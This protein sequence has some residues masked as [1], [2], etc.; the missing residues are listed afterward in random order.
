MRWE[1]KR[2]A[3][4]LITWYPHFGGDKVKRML[5]WTGQ[6]RQTTNYAHIVHGFDLTSS[7]RK[8]RRHV[9]HHIAYS[10]RFNHLLI[11]KKSFL[12]NKPGSVLWWR[13][14]KNLTEQLLTRGDISSLLHTCNPIEADNLFMNLSLQRVVF[15]TCCCFDYKQTCKMG[16]GSRLYAVCLMAARRKCVSPVLLW[17][18]EA[19]E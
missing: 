11:F 13:A 14:G 12:I 6:C 1:D 9:C 8:P 18:Q 17:G 2:Q 3:S 15:D 10:L 7:N 4:Q 16:A 5:A 19:F